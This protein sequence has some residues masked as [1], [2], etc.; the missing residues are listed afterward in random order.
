MNKRP[1]ISFCALTAWAR[2]DAF[3]ADALPG[4]SRKVAREVCRS[5]G[6]VHDG[7]R[8]KPG[9]AVKACALI[10]I[11]A[12]SRLSAARELPAPPRLEVLHEDDDLVIVS[13]P[14]AVHSITL[15]DD[16]P[17]TLA[18]MLAT[19]WPACRSASPDG[20]EAGLVQRLDYYTSGAVAAAKT[21]SC[22]QAL[23]TLISEKQV[24]KTYLALVEGRLEGKV[25]CSE[26][27]DGR[28]AETAVQGI[29]VLKNG[30]SVV[31]AAAPLARRH[32]IRRH[33]A[34]L[35][36]PLIGDVEYGS[37]LSLSAFTGLQQG[38]LLHAESLEFTQPFSRTA[39]GVNAG[40]AA[41]K[42]LLQCN[43]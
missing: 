18:D 28:E 33:L 9:T 38:F 34:A 6:V 20:R 1:L 31:R 17:P 39:L 41:F 11:A 21:R 7:I 24:K 27:L 8:A 40:S 35:G 14:R 19:L 37:A 29:R 13:K 3:L 2:I 25:C 23:R 30:L 4:V 15:R 26:P 12:L 10:E 16:D 22:W 42:A 43:E 36:H 5:G 32:Q